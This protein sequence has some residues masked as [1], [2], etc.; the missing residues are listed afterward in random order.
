MFFY[1][2]WYYG[3][4]IKNRQRL[5]MK[6]FLLLALVSGLA[7]CGMADFSKAHMSLDFQKHTRPG[8]P[9]F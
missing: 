4:F 2:E 1:F 8:D 7:S 6:Y 5:L 9:G 3:N